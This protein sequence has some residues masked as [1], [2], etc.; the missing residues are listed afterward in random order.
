MTIL[1][2]MTPTRI[3]GMTV[4]ADHAVR[5]GCAQERQSGIRAIGK[6]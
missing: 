6:L 4:K 2:T 5:D 1:G 3:D